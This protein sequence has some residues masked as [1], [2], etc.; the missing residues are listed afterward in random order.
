MNLPARMILNLL[1]CLAI[2]A[3]LA[4]CASTVAEAPS[5]RGVAFSINQPSQQ[6]AR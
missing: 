1:I 5:C 4:S 3:F 6:A 2:I